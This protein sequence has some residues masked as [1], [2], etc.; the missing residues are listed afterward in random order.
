MFNKPCLIIPTTVLNTSSNL[1]QVQVYWGNVKL[2]RKTGTVTANGADTIGFIKSYSR[3]IV[4]SLL[5]EWLPAIPDM[6][7]DLMNCQE[8]WHIK[9][10]SILKYTDP[11]HPSVKRSLYADYYNLLDEKRCLSCHN[12]LTS[13]SEGVK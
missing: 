8:G 12:A 4:R 2:T 7:P 3:I 9:G 5:L 6:Y 13:I 11:T 1:Y 10:D